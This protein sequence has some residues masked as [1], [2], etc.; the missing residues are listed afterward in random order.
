MCWVP[1]VPQAWA[2]VLRVPAWVLHGPCAALS[3]ESVALHL[4]LETSTGPSAAPSP[5]GPW[6]LSLSPGTVYPHSFGKLAL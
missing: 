5:C 1:V 6:G 2:P 4:L 3:L